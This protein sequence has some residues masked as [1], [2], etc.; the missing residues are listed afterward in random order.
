MDPDDTNIFATNI[1]EKYENP[2]P[3]IWAA[4]VKCY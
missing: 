2:L 3:K 1:I 4:V